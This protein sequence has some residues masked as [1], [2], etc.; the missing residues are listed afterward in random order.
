SAD[1]LA[2]YLGWY[3]LSKLARRK[4][5][6]M[7]TRAYLSMGPTIATCLGRW[8]LS[9]ANPSLIRKPDLWEEILETSEF[10]LD[11]TAD[12]FDFVV[13]SGSAEDFGVAELLF[14]REVSP[15]IIAIL[16]RSR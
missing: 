8:A 9:N 2:S 6:P 15:R 16:K 5:R 12:G 7:T 11:E 4:L 1:K 13:R 10:F 3:I 14:E